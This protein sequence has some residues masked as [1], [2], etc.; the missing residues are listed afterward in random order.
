MTQT[1]ELLLDEAAEA[2]VVEQWR[3]LDRAGL[4]SQAQHQ[5]PS[6]RP[7]VTLASVPD[8]DEPQE[9]QVVAACRAGLPV[10]AVLG[11]LTV[12]GRD[13]VVL[14]RLVVATSALLDLHEAVARVTQTR[15]GDLT[16]PG[17]WVPHV[18]LANRLPRERLSDALALLPPGGVP[19]RLASARRWDS[20]ARRSWPV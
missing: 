11:P 3:V 5:S 12:F 8:L 10:P 18:T 19:T 2:L 14:V 6:N 17:R 9:E 13:P 1:V 20:E 4:P 16:A 15:E 7:H